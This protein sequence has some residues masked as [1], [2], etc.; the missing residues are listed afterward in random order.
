MPKKAVSAQS[1]VESALFSAFKSG[2]GETSLSDIAR[3][4]G[5]KK[6]SLYNY[7]A[8]KEEILGALCS[9]CSDFY[10]RMNIF[11]Q[12]IF[13]KINSTN[14]EKLFKKSVDAYIRSHENEPLFQIYT[15]VQSEK[16]FD[17][18]FL[19]IS[20]AQ[21][22]KVFDQSF[23]FFK[24]ASAQTKGSAQKS[25]EELRLYSHFFADGILTRLDYYIAQKKE[26]I[27]RNPECDAGSLF[28]LPSDEK[29]ITAITAFAVEI[30]KNVI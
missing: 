26:T 15:L 12:E 2:M 14:C 19:D 24:I 5:I 7:Y 1:I 6:A 13:A 4:L 16:Y 28:A 30:L 29:Q 21:G 10:S 11:E 17:K 9:Y 3:D 8:G 27:R 23:L 22:K 20:Q 25:D 18:N